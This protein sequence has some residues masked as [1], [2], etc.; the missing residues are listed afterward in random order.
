MQSVTEWKQNKNVSTTSKVKSVSQWK[1]TQKPF[2]IELERE[3]LRK[4]GLAVGFNDRKAEPTT[5]GNYIRGVAK[6][7]ADVATNVVNTGQIAVGAKE[8][9]PF[10][11]GYLGKVEGLG[12]VD[13]SKS[14]FDKDNLKVIINSASTGAEIASYL[15]AG[16]VAKS[17]VTDLTKRG[18]LASKKTFAE[19]VVTNFPKLAK[20]GFLQGV[21]YTAGSQ[22]R[23]YVAS[24]KKPSIEQAVKD[25]ALSTIGT[26]AV[27]A[28]VRGVFGTSSKKILTAR[29]TERAISDARILGR[30][31]PEAGVPS[32]KF[33]QE[34]NRMLPSARKPGEIPIELPEKGILESQAKIRQYE[35]PTPTPKTQPK[36]DAQGFRPVGKDEILP[37]GYT[38]KM[39]TQTGEQMTN[40]PLK[41][42]PSTPTPNPSIQSKIYD[43]PPEIRQALPEKEN[44]ILK[45]VERMADE[46]EGFEPSS[47]VQFSQEIRKLDPEEIMNVAMGGEKKVQNTIPSNAYLSI[48]KN[49]AEETGNVKMIKELASSDVASKAG[50]GLVSSRMTTADNIVDDLR[51]VRLQ[52]LRSKKI[53][54]AKI[55]REQGTLIEKIQT[56]FKEVSKVTKQEVDNIINSLICK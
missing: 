18:I 5:V 9:K 25:V 24:G 14:P 46:L 13:V 20:E 54:E 6:L 2:Q 29:E 19:W 51:Q 55:I 10:S 52:K 7:G 16:G 8:T 3:E 40:A 42:I 11:G 28:V 43:I 34:N 30:P 4:Q 41:D 27:P 45:D 23:E 12:K 33:M 56:K 32:A 35:V 36:V 39:N 21:A 49:I 37:N 38:T 26:I 53:D 15:T 50:Q 47:F 17:T 44:I 31:I 22:G 1:S 48:A